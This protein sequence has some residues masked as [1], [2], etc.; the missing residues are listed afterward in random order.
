MV[1]PE[2]RTEFR[3]NRLERVVILNRV[4]LAVVEEMRGKHPVQVSTYRGRPIKKVYGAA[5]R[6]ARERA[7]LPQVRV[8]DLKHTFGGR[9]RA[10]GVSF[11]DRQDL[12]GHKSSRITTHY[13][14]A[15]LSNLIIAANKM[16]DQE[17]R[18]SPALVIP[19][20]KP[21]LSVVN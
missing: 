4:A 2:F 18:K 7:D 13:S 1:S 21:R 17:S 16:C 14:Q 9:F 10:A 5:W 6:E 19:K 15:E 11:Q 8:H 12:S 3:N 20:K